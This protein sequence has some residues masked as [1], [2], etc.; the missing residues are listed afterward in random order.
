VVRSGRRRAHAA[1]LVAVCVALALATACTRAPDLASKRVQNP[2][3]G[4]SVNAAAGHIRLLAVRVEAPDD[5]QHTAG[6]NVGLFLTVANDGPAADRLAAVSTANAEDVVMRDGSGSPAAVSVD[7]PPRSAVSLQYPGALHLELVDLSLD[8]R[9][10][11]F[12]PVLFRFQ[13]AGTVSV[14]VFV[15]GYAKPT[16]A[17]LPASPSTSTTATP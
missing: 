15:Q 1:A 4:S 12:L 3:R 13:T 14:D 17:P 9:G 16:V 2:V 6:D 11:V 5:D 8:T 7:V 10:G